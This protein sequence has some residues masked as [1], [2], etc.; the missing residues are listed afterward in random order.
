MTDSL[1]A[2]KISENVY[3]VGAI[4]W[5][6]RNF[7]GYLTSRG[8]TYNAYLIMGEKITL[9]DTVKKE[10]FD[11]MMLRIS[12][13]VDPTKIDYIISNHSEMDHSGSLP[14]ALKKLKP[15]KLFASK[16]GQRALVNHFHFD[17]D[18]ITVV[19]DGDT[20]DMGGKK[21]SFVETK[22]CHW[23]DSMVSFLHEDKL[24]FSQDAFG[25]HLASFERFADE[26]DREILYYE[27]AK[28][29]A[30]I[31]LHLSHVIQGTLEK[32]GGLELD[33]QMVAP[34]HGPIWR[35]PE[36]IQYILGN[37]A[38]WAEQK[39]S[40]RA[41]VLFDTMW[42]STE[43][44][45]ASIG[46]G[47]SSK[48]MKV[49]LMKASTCHRS[50]V[51]TELLDAGALI[52]GS[53]TINNNIFPALGDHLT[54]IKGLKPRNLIG[55]SFGSFG[56]SGEAPRHL[57]SMM[58]DMGI[59]MVAGPQRINYVPDNADL[60]E[61]ADLGERVAVAMKAALAGRPIPCWCKKAPKEDVEVKPCKINVNDGHKI[62]ETLTG[63]SLFKALEDH[64]ILLPTI[65]GGEGLCGCCKVSVTD[66]DAGPLTTS[67][68]D[69]LT[70]SQ[71]E[72][73][74]RL[75][76]QVTLRGDLSVTVPEESLGAVKYT[77]TVESIED[78]THDIK[79]IT[80]KLDDPK[81][82]D[83]IPGHYVKLDVPETV[84]PAGI[85]RAYSLASCPSCHD[86]IELMIR[87]VPNGACTAW[88][89]RKLKVGDKVSFSGPFGDFQM[90]NTDKEMIWV[91]GGSGMS[92]FISM[93][94][95]MIQNNIKRKVRYFFGAVTKADLFLVDQLKQWEKEH[96]WFTFIPALSAPT[97]ED[98]WKGETGLITEVL[99]RHVK[100]FEGM[101]A[102]LCGS[103]GMLRACLKVL[104]DKGLT[105]DQ[106][107]YDE[108]GSLS[109]PA[110]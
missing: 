99:D 85:S 66:G 16:M 51:I 94:K 28:Y 47:L 30:N 69:Q 86:K 106:I 77:A 92:P 104:E 49:K 38:K 101:E 56:W 41:V 105:E 27:G 23:P 98:K 82:I 45:A 84:E 89:F 1:K 12:S 75:G 24:M 4:D 108:F 19:G 93:L 96:D 43:K 7:H 50:D 11:E 48:G 52:V 80:L 36:D 42:G 15:E 33:I 64:K 79:H 17:P 46:D 29:F 71:I 25:M 100:D 63:Q 61:C 74:V 70:H 20:I 90:T 78:M 31:L 91:A 97:A 35:T 88:V 39:P 72:R 3:W 110:K 10:F 21:V 6:V 5:D 58:E 62:I 13:V 37:Y 26:I 60:A 44:M 8:T 34:D 54:Y 95:Y 107:Y 83:V 18:M 32:V 87:K 103:P 2:V 109:A 22:M 76:C 53:P 59:N 67:E 68:R 81:S 73:G 9:V 40:D 55:A 65:C 102:Y 57:H 14:K